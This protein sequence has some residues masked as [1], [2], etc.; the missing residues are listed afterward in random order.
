M[1]VDPSLNNHELDFFDDDTD[2]DTY[3]KKK[4]SFSTNSTLFEGSRYENKGGTFTTG[5]N[6]FSK[7]EQKK[8]E[9]RAKRFGLKNT[10]K[11]IDVEDEKEL[12]SSMGVFDDNE[13]TKYIRL[14]VLH[15]RG[16]D[17]MSTQDVF[18]YFKDYAP[19]SIEWINDM[20]CNVVWLDNI[21]AARAL[22][23]LSK[24]IVGLNDKIEIGTNKIEINDSN[25]DDE[26]NTINLRNIDFPL[27]PGIWRK[28]VNCDKS[29]KILLRFAINSDKKQPNAE[30]LSEYYKKY[31]NPNFGGMR[32]ILTDSRKRLYR[33]IKNKQKPSD[34]IIED[35]EIDSKN[36]WGSLSEAWGTNDSVEKDF[37]NQSQT[38][39]SRKMAMKQIGIK[40]RL[41]VKSKNKTVDDNFT[42]SD[43]NSDSDDE[44]GK[45]TKVLRMRMHA[46]DEEEKVQKRKLKQLT[47]RMEE[48]ISNCDL[49]SRLQ[50]MNSI[51]YKEPI[52]VTVTNSP[53]TLRI[54][55]ENENVEKNHIEDLIDNNIKDK[56]E[57]EW[58]NNEEDMENN[59]NYSDQM[60][61]KVDNEEDN[62]DCDSDISEKEVQGP[63]G[64]VI[65]VVQRA[66]P[67]VASTVWAR[68][69][70]SENS[71]TKEWEHSGNAVSSGDLRSRLSH[72]RE[73]SPLR[74][75]VR[76]DKYTK[77]NSTNIIKKKY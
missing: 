14:N 18:N 21:S 46:D 50:R 29:Q 20:S 1:E 34:K 44:W 36:P 9:E 39:D 13:N 32:G 55:T 59:E 71:H 5:I 52:K 76:N 35:S 43:T 19:A 49:R 24:K 51:V 69:N 77:K 12:Y 17:E 41:G 23:G 62:S 3:I 11:L 72:N 40:R 68:L 26:K 15:M 63:K 65:K 54:E 66:K 30:K 45:R 37:I 70:H 38:K 57:G 7:E 27:P 31:G 47:M 42:S 60:E 58:E 74:I 6:I 10:Q 67:R 25:E 22:I 28:G 61:E 8:M 48:K 2:L 33:D 73:R 64:S 4:K 56:E 75:E 16:T 53:E